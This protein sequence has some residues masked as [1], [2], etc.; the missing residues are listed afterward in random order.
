MRR[1]AAAAPPPAPATPPPFFF[2][3]QAGVPRVS[4]AGALGRQVCCCTRAAATMPTEKRAR[5]VAE[6]ADSH[7]PASSARLPPVDANTT[8]HITFDQT[9]PLKTLI[10]VVSNVLL[11]VEVCIVKDDKFEG[12]QIESIDHKHVCL[13]YA[14]LAC[15]V[16]AMGD[17]AKFCVDTQTLNT[18][19]KAIQPHVSVDIRGYADSSDVTL[20][21]YETISNNYCTTFHIPTLVSDA[22]SIKLTSMD[23]TFTVELDVNTLRNIVKNTLMLKGSDIRFRVEEQAESQ[24]YRYTVFTIATDG[25]AKQ[26]HQ[27]HSV[28]ESKGGGTCI[29]RT[30]ETGV[31]LPSVGELRVRYE[32]SFSA[33]YISNFLKSMERQNINLLLSK[34]KPLI[35]Q[36]PLGAEKSKIWFVLAPKIKD[37]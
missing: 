25:N 37:A 34:D 14:K 6:D 15:K 17:D 21:G 35:L 3:G 30:D 8:F 9:I 16:N 10:D 22:E 29:I 19:L 13:I 26:T 24:P 7:P 28:T 32:D 12:I 1:R 4:L 31:D 11:R 36:Y 18:C 27:F 5:E 2:S 23:Y 20:H 33:T